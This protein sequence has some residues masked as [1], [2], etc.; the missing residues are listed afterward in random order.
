MLASSRGHCGGAGLRGRDKSRPYESIL[1]FGPTG[2]AAATRAAVGRDALI[3]PDI[4][5]ARTFRF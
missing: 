1:C 2:M 5:A 4:A 3:P